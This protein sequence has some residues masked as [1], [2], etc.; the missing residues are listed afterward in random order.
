MKYDGIIEIAIGRNRK[1]TRWQTTPMQWSDF[2]ER[3]SHTQRTSETMTEYIAAA[4]P[5]QDEIKDVGGYV[6]GVVKGGRRKAENVTARRLITLDID[7]ASAGTWEVVKLLYSEAAL[8]Y[9]THKHRED[10]WRLRLVM[11][12]SREVDACEYE[13]IA[14]RI[15]GNV[16]ID[17][18]DD[19]TYEPSRLMYWPSTPKDGDYFFDVQDGAWLN[20]D[21]VLAT[22]RDYRDASQWP[23]S[24]RTRQVITR[25]I[26]KAGDPR[27][28]GGLIGAFCRTYD[29]HAAIST[30]L[31]DVYRPEEDGKAR[32]RYTYAGGSTSNG[33]VTYDDLFAYSH[34]G[35]DPCSGQLCNAFDL[36]RVGLFGLK[37]ENCKEETPTSR[38][39]SY[40]A[41]ME[42]VEAD[43]E[44]QKTINRE[45]VASLHDDFA[46]DAPEGTTVDDS[47]ADELDNDKRGMRGTIGNYMLILRGDPN[48]KDKLRYNE[49]ANRA[50]VMGD[51]PWRRKGDRTEWR[52][53]D[54]AGLYAYIESVYETL[55]RPNVDFAVTNIFEEHKYHPVRDYLR[56]LQWD[57]TPRVEDLF[58]HYLGAEDTPYTRTV[59]RKA[60]CAAVARVMRPATKFDNCIVLVGAQGIGKSTVLHTLGK[61]WFSDNFIAIKGKEAVEQIQGVW[62]MEI[63]ELAGLRKAE[64]EDIKS[65]MSTTQ[66]R[67]RLAYARRVSVFPR[68]TVFFATTNTNEFLND[69]TGNR[70]FWPI[71]VQRPDDECDRFKSFTDAEADQVWAEAVV[72]YDAGEEL[73]LS[74]ELAESATL[75]QQQH[76]MQDERVG[77]IQEYLDTPLPDEW[78]DWGIYDRRNYLFDDLSPRR[79]SR[80]DRVCAVE[81]WCECFGR[82]REEYGRKENVDITGLL[83]QIDGWQRNPNPVEVKGIGRQR[84]FYRIGGK[85]RVKSMNP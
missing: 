22:Y 18:F 28:K 19:S 54:D 20:A 25:E 52:D 44:T 51:L 71:A 56:G 66:D 78:D 70:R 17:E 59:T 24:S 49:F 13:A 82:R 7:F 81:V 35:S 53:S 47:W 46:A 69:P 2:V 33:L 12:L 11:P 79:G 30:F 48:I 34:H 83:T 16:G 64:I 80:R 60:L 5:R 62:I 50:E 10:A 32:G 26:R 57:G 38:L 55:N 77:I 76:C 1:D 31:S 65:Y 72:M 23:T 29:I 42:L 43:K 4:K 3:V 45:R 21:K 85:N 37:D 41:M 27:D 84:V 36:V 9:S 67:I 6:G 58:V 39:P 8:V 63:S 68:Q 40:A 15:A 14:R 73:Y 75:I 61:S 74:R